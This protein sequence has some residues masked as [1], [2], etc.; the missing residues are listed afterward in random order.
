MHVGDFKLSPKVHIGDF[1]PS[2]KVLIGD[3]KP[4]PK[5]H[6][7][8]LKLSLRYINVTQTVFYGIY[9]ISFSFVDSQVDSRFS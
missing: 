8:D 6:I 2:P 9:I 3:F 7:G 4:I 1:K 5:V